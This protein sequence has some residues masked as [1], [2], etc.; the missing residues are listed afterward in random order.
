MAN[1]T[2]FVEVDAV[3]LATYGFRASGVSG[4][5][6]SPIVTLTEQAMYQREGVQ[7]MDDEPTTPP[8]DIV[9]TGTIIGDDQGDFESLRLAL[10]RFLGPRGA[11]DRTLVFGNQPD[12][13][14]TA[15]FM[16]S[17]ATPTP[18]VMIQG[19]V[20]TDLRFR[21]LDA[22][23]QDTTDQVV[24]A[25]AA[26]PAP[27]PLGTERCRGTTSTTLSG[28]ASSVTFT[29]KHHDGTTLGSITVTHAFV[30]SDVV[31]VDHD[32]M[33][34]LVNGTPHAEYLSDGS[35]FRFD[36]LDGD[37]SA[38]EWPTVQV[39]HGALTVTYRRRW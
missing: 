6:D 39:D 5:W 19:R 26:T 32:N 35:F 2:F 1:P 16:G 13:Q 24:T 21:V 20:S 14:Y 15:R 27:I 34:I 33:L 23:A 7:L 18:P 8:V 3:D 37:A 31:A 36:P 25:A 12:R 30:T 11:F 10:L 22:L 38:S 4:L 28:S 29:Y 9:V 17:P